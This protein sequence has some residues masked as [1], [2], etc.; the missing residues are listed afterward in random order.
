[1]E[2]KY[3]IKLLPEETILWEGNPEA[4]QTLDVTN[5]PAFVKKS[6]ITIPIVGAILALYILKALTVQIIPIAFLLA[7]GG[8][9]CCS[10]ILNARKLRNIRYIITN[11]RILLVTKDRT[12]SAAYGDI[13]VANLR[14]DVDGHTSLLCGE[15]AVNLAPDQWRSY[16]AIGVRANQSGV[17]DSLVLYAIPDP[18]KVR[19]ILK[20]YLTVN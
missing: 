2:N 5:K 12:T 4:F 11:K 18:E 13:P 1:M 9:I 7:L 16:T 10:P 8:Y 3:N 19:E 6:L 20:P 17:C 15:S 14:S